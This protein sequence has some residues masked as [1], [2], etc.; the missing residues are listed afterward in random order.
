MRVEAADGLI[1]EGADRRHEIIQHAG[2]M[3]ST[4]SIG[5][6]ASGGKCRPKARTSWVPHIVIV[7]HAGLLRL[8][9]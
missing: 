5:G 2:W 3:A 8:T 7:A 9:V 4:G 6:S 1:A